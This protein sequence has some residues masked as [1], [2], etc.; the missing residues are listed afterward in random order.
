ME[1]NA[2]SAK[3]ILKIIVGIPA[4]RVSWLPMT[5]PQ[6][7]L[8]AGALLA[9]V[10]VAIYEANQAAQARAE[11]R[12]AQS[13]PAPLAG[14]FEQLQKERDAATNR[15]AWLNDELAKAK[16]NNREL[17]KLRGEVTV[18]KMQAAAAKNPAPDTNAADSIL[19]DVNNA[20]NVALDDGKVLNFTNGVAVV[21]GA[22]YPNSAT[23]RDEYRILR[24]LASDPHHDCCEVSLDSGGSGSFASLGI[25]TKGDDQAVKSLQMLDVGDRTQIYN[26]DT[27]DSGDVNVY[28]LDRRA[29]EG[30]A[31]TPTL[32]KKKV[33]QF[34]PATGKYV[35]TATFGLVTDQPWVKEP[36]PSAK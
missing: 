20:R 32:P 19:G 10:G 33:F 3:M 5:V 16:S 23:D 28:Y 12:T 2:R 36:T 29:D 31:T 14:S 35:G 26:V 27:E 24:F 21:P 15:M 22:D 7:I 1:D 18:L 11:A 17:L 25:F 13:P 8:V 4:L 6:K 30:M 34:D 9:A